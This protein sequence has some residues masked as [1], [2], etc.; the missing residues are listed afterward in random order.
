[1]PRK[2]IKKKETD[3][4]NKD[5]K[6]QSTKDSESNIDV[7]D[8]VVDNALEKDSS[9][10]SDIDDNDTISDAFNYD[11]RKKS[12]QESGED[13]I[14]EEAQAEYIQTVV[15]DRVVKYIKIDDIIKKK[16]Q[17]HK[18]ELKAI[19]DSKDKLEQFLIDYLD[20]IDEEYIQIGNKGTLIKTE[21][22]TKAPPKMEDITL[23]LIEGFKK[24]EIYDDDAEIK[25]VV[26]DFIETIEAK[27][28]IKVRKYLKRTKGNP[29]GK[30][31]DGKK[32]EG[33]GKKGSKQ[34]KAKSS[35]KKKVVKKVKKED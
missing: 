11:V 23:S 10:I 27:R 18:K 25:R 21:S 29:N 31:K 16:Q 34:S 15:L 28:E 12:Q 13:E 26:K 32:K 14:D 22:K 20:K 2:A 35:G 4:A 30:D 5:S 9:D 17:D 24:F 19:K 33:S 7:Q 8:D 6:K 1:M 3:V